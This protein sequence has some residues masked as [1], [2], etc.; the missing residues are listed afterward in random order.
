MGKNAFRRLLALTTLVG[1]MA[2]FPAAA[3]CKPGFIRSDGITG[4][5][6]DAAHQGWFQSAAVDI[7]GMGSGMSMP[8]ASGPGS[9]ELARTERALRRSSARASDTTVRIIGRIL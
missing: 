6:G 8:S 1:V 9:F 3:A 2:V 7:V 4:D 5:G